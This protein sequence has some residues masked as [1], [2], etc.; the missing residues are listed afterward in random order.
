VKKKERTGS[1]SSSNIGLKN[2]KSGDNRLRAIP[3]LENGTQDLMSPLLIE[4]NR[5]LKKIDSS[6]IVLTDTAYQPISGY[7][8]RLIQPKQKSGSVIT[9]KKTN[10]FV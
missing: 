2:N 8:L 4:F 7:T 6:R 10:H 5:P 3:S 9:G 1:S